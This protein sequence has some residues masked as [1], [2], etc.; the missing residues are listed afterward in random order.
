MNNNFSVE[1]D[2]MDNKLPMFSV[3]LQYW[4]K[5]IMSQLQQS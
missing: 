1:K 5:H 2:P 3:I 4:G